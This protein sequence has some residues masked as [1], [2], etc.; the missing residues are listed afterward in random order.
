MDPNEWRE[1]LRE[2]I[3]YGML[4]K[5]V[6]KDADSVDEAG[7]KLTYRPMLES[8]S[9]WAERRHHEYRRQFARLGGKVHVQETRDKFTYFVLVTVRGMQH[10]NI[11]SVEILRAECQ[12]RLNQYFKAIGISPA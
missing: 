1:I 6:A 12:E 2:F 4:F 5:A 3:V 11:Y 10:E 9:I 7:L 8:I